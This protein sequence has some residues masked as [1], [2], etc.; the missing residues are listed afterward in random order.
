MGFDYSKP[1]MDPDAM[2]I[3][4]PRGMRTR[5]CNRCGQPWYTHEMHKIVDDDSRGGGKW[6]C[7]PCFD[8][9]YGEAQHKRGDY[10]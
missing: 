4:Y 6:Y 5:D 3:P 9:P 8:R 2:P 10:R 1:K 7:R